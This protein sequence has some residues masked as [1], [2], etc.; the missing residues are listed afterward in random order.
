MPGAVAGVIRATIV[1]AAADGRPL[2]VWPGAPAPA[3]ADAVWMAASPRWSDCAGL[4]AVVGFED[5]DPSRPVLLGLLGA[6]P[7]HIDAEGGDAM[8]AVHIEGRD[9]LV[10]Q[11]GEAKIVLRADGS[12]TIRGAKVVTRARGVNKIR[13]GSVQIN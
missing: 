13:G 5:G 3:V 11:C 2:V 4:G 8:Q 7:G 10:L 9:A 12:V 1:G 6:P